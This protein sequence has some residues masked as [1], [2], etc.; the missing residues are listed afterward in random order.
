ME[1]KLEVNDWF[2]NGEVTFQRPGQVE[3]LG[4]D[5]LED[6]IHIYVVCCT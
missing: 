5:E 6:L 2:S 1:V 4:C 3:E